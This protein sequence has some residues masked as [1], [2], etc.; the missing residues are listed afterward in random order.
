MHTRS[1]TPQDVIELNDKLPKNWNTQTHAHFNGE[2]ARSYIYQVKNG[3]YFN[4]KIQDYIYKLALKSQRAIKSR[5][6]KIKEA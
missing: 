4:K 6:L 5:T 3:L 2:F 1:F